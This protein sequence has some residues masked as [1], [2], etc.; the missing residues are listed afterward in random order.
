MGSSLNQGTFL[1]SLPKVP[2]YNGY[3]KRDPNLGNRP[4]VFALS[5][6]CVCVGVGFVWGSGA[7]GRFAGW[8]PWAPGVWFRHPAV[9]NLGMSHLEA[10]TP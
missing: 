5:C 9:G 7:R 3:P 10:Y 1:R 2:P 4:D 6:V 8:G